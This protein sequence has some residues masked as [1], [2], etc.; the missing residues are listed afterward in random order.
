[1][2]FLYI[3]IGL[4]SFGIF[5]YLLTII[6]VTSILYTK[7]FVRTSKEKWSRTVSWPD[8]ELQHMF[9]EGKLWG[10][11]YDSYRKT[12]N[13]NS[14]GFNL[15]AEYFDFGYDKTVIIIPGRSESGTYSY[16]FSEPYRKSGYNVLAIDNRCHGLSEGKYNTLGLKEYKDVLAWGKLIHN[17]YHINKIYIH[18]ICIGSATAIHLLS[19]ENVPSYF[20]GL[21]AEGT[22]I[23]FEELFNNQLRKRKKPVFPYTK[24]VLFLIRLKAGVSLKKNSPINEIDRI[25]V[26]ILFLYSKQDSFAKPDKSLELFNKVTS[27]KKLVWFDEGEHSHIR[28]HNMEK[29]DNSIIEFLKENIDE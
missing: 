14:E 15:V 8:E 7:L 29:Y 26:P 5:M 27:K 2:I 24:L 25:K 6:V 12:L 28:I 10:E 20:V 16:Y 23:T 1:M 3:A 22:Y 4:V 21:T 17:E 19:R 11:K 18:G 13:I 9:D